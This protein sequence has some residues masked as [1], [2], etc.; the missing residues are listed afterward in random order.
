MTTTGPLPDLS[1]QHRRLIV[2]VTSGASHPQISAGPGV[3]VAANGV[4]AAIETLLARTRTRTVLHLAAWPTAQRIV[5]SPVHPTG[6]FTIKPQL[7]PRLSQILR[8]WST[9]RSTT[10]LT[11]EW[12]IAPN[13]MRTYTETLLTQLGV[14]SQPQ[15]GVVGVLS[16]L[17]LLSDT[18]ASWAAEPLARDNGQNKP[19]R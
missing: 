13:T 8:G 16:G 7:T 6:A 3:A 10:E 19:S 18:N 2:L 15:A 5:T 9:G 1:D 14:D 17:T 4:R 12:G 11:A